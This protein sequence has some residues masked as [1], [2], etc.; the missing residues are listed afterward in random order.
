MWVFAALVNK[1]HPGNIPG[2][3][4][5]DILIIFFSILHCAQ[6]RAAIRAVLPVLLRKS[7]A[8]GTLVLLDRLSHGFY[9]DG[10]FHDRNDHRGNYSLRGSYRRMYAWHGAPH[11]ARPMA[12]V[13]PQDLPDCCPVQ[14]R[15]RNGKK[16]LYQ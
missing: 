9:R 1:K 4:L 2:C 7:A 12:G 8:V 10:C 14:F 6:R 16:V 13:S 3:F 15:T 11:I 5:P